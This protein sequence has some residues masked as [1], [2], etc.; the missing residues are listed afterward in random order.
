MSIE[1]I[2]T[3]LIT[4]S[5]NT[6][7]SGSAENLTVE[8]GHE[9][10]LSHYT[11][12]DDQGNSEG[13]WTIVDGD[14]TVAD[15]FNRYGDH[16]TSITNTADWNNDGEKEIFV[17]TA[18]YEHYVQSTLNTNLSLTIENYVDVNLHTTYLENTG[19]LQFRIE[20]AKRGTIDL[21]DGRSGGVQLDIVAQSNGPSW[22]NMFEVTGSSGSDRVAIGG[23]E[24]TEYT[25]FSMDLAAG[26]D[27][28]TASVLNAPASASQT[29]FVDGGDGVDTISIHDTEAG[30]LAEVDF[31]NFEIISANEH[32]LTLNEDVLSH[33]GTQDAP[34]IVEN[35]T[36][37]NFAGDVE[38]I[39]AKEY[40]YVNDHGVHKDGYY[41]VTVDYDDASYTIISDNVDDAWL[42]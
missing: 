21:S 7:G 1:I 22:G 33:N 25:E 35:T 14:T 2:T 24:G 26:D 27:W 34:L 18:D 6:D 39:T 23:K 19:E 32:E 5:T 31:V 11:T 8:N 36:E 15:R 37:L 9:I 4:G 17:D 40:D 42:V 38:S 10:D 29:R 41:E 13:A 20:G 28:F 30:T 3:S 12:F 16:E